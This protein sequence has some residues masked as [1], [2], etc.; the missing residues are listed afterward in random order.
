M[1]CPED[2][3][4]N[5]PTPSLTSLG[6]MIFQG[7]PVT[8]EFRR[9]LGYAEQADVHEPTATVR[10]AL[11]F[12]AQLRQPSG[13]SV[14]AKYAHVE[15]IM[16]LLDMRHLAGAIVGRPGNGLNLEQRKRL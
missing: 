10:E 13:I 9:K 3:Q 11:R 16:D 7:K 15:Q 4:G 1:V 14:A 12:A 2:V 8:P 5:L 6:S